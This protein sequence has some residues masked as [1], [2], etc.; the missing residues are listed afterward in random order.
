M[1]ID[2]HSHAWDFPAD[3]SADFIR[4]A[5]RARPG[6]AVDYSARYEA[7]RATAPED[8]CTIVF[9]GKARLSGLWV[10][11]ATVARYVANDPARLIGFLSV[12]PTQPDWEM[13]LKRG[14]QELGLVEH[15]SRSQFKQLCPGLMPKRGKSTSSCM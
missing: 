15:Q 10:N 2:V 9:G 6:H 13:D 7:Y 12:D 14:H 3:F 1:I 4:Q 8:T 5:S 11:D